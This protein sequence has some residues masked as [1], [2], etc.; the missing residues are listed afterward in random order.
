[1]TSSFVDKLSSVSYATTKQKEKE[2]WDVEGILKNR[3]NVKYKFDTRPIKKHGDYFGKLGNTKSKADKMVFKINKD[4]LIID[5]KELHSYIKKNKL[6]KVHLQNL[7]KNL[8]WNI[9]V[10]K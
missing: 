10:V 9:C 8:E 3:L 7:I 2:L 4:Y 5:V 6:N 1:M